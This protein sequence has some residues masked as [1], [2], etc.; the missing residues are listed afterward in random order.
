MENPGEYLKRER[1]QR[2]VSLSRIAESTRVPLK[3]LEALE[4]DDFDSLPHPAFVKGYIKSYCKVLGLD[5]TDA[6]LR[7][8]LFLREKN[9]SV[10][11]EEKAAEEARKKPFRFSPS[12]IPEGAAP[13]GPVSAGYVITAAVIIIA[14]AVIYY[15][16][17]SPRK[18]ATMTEQPE[19]PAAEN[20]VTTEKPASE[21]V[22]TQAAPVEGQ[23]PAASV[24][25][26]EA[27][28]HASESPAAGA[29][30]PS[31][32]HSLTVSASEL[33]WVKVAIDDDE[34][35]DVVLRPGEKV[36][37]KASKAF[38]L[39]VGNAGGVNIN[40]D[41]EEFSGLGA[42][43]EVVKLVFPKGA[44]AQKVKKPAVTVPKATGA[45]MAPAA[46]I[47]ASTAPAPA[48]APEAVKKPAPA[49]TQDTSAGISGTT[50]ITTSAAPAAPKAVK[51][52]AAPAAQDTGAG[53]SGTAAGTPPGVD[54]GGVTQPKWDSNPQEK[55]EVRPIE[56]MPE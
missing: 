38:H 10:E 41:G 27:A 34:P 20:V 14:V 23:V 9:G 15:Y 21:A 2:D 48:R 22:T 17:S 56:G 3:F 25:P 43:G 37:W 54:D 35:F 47:N 19:A 39:V 8:E 40:F 45:A 31:Q 51:K 18:T 49:A 32:R 4:A 1:E 24:A 46:G 50:G 30:V 13:S 16:T 44:P 12:G 29:V 6:V 52:P 55:F 5:E 7:Y 11:E 53:I 33:S 26:A 36:S 42:S 28:R